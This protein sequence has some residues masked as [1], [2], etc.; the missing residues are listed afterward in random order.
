MRLFLPFVSYAFLLTAQISSVTAVRLIETTALDIVR[1]GNLSITHFS[2]VFT[3]DNRTANLRIIGETGITGRVL[4]DINLIVYGY[5]TDPSTTDPCKV[6]ALTGFCPMN[7]GPLDMI[8]TN[9]PV[10]NKTLG[11]VPSIAYS[12]PDLD[13][14][15]RLEV[16]SNATREVITILE[17]RLS[18]GRTTYQPA[19]GWIVAVFSGLALILSVVVPIFRGHSDAAVRLTGYTFSL[20][21]FLQAQA[22]IG[23]LAVPMPPIVQSWTHNFQWTMGVVHAKFLETLCT[24]YLRSTGGTADRLLDNLST[25]MVNVRKRDNVTPLSLGNSIAR[26]ADSTTTT[27]ASDIFVQGLTRVAFRGSIEATNLFLTAILVLTFVLLIV[28]ILI[29]LWK[30]AQF[31]PRMRTTQ[32][33]L[34]SISKGILYRVYFLAFAPICILSLWELTQRDS[35]AEIL[36]AIV[37]FLCILCAVVWAVA[38]VLI[39]RQRA[40]AMGRSPIYTLFADQSLMHKYGFLYMHFKPV[41]CYFAAVTIASIFIKA[42]FVS[43]AQSSPKAQAVAFLIIEIAMLLAI[44]IIRPWVDKK[45][46]AVNIT[47]AAINFLYSIFVLFFSNVFNQPR[48]VAGVMGVILFVSSAALILVLLGFVVYYAVRTLLD[49]RSQ[50]KPY[51]PM[52]EASESG[53]L[54]RSSTR[55]A[56]EH[57]ELDELSATSRGIVKHEPGRFPI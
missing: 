13:A 14:I 40:L 25:T 21:G 57:T 8:M 52:S 11:S 30:A 55:L 28:M 1:P 37:S 44:S 4:A 19:V 12:I 42:L 15:V 33:Q 41:A 2:G 5:A 38:H 50:A 56:G 31:H 29:G 39:M 46:N 54:V 22:M 43:F 23:M 53:G 36:V 35:P 7:E 20:F 49:A 6:K 3:P 10:D 9:I 45:S 18:N 47:V 16:K 51:R 24:W 17:A 27:T 26:R 34:Q 48:M 32:A